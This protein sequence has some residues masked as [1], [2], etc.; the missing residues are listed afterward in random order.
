MANNELRIKPPFEEFPFTSNSLTVSCRDHKTEGSNSI[1]PCNW[2]LRLYLLKVQGSM[3]RYRRLATT[4]FSALFLIQKIQLSNPTAS[5]SQCYGIPPGLGSSRLISTLSLGLASLMRETLEGAGDAGSVEESW[6]SM[7]GHAVCS[8]TLL[9]RSFKAFRAICLQIWESVG[10]K[11]HEKH[12][13][14]NVYTC[15]CFLNNAA[16]TSHYR[17]LLMFSKHRLHLE[18]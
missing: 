16:C 10:R 4:I 8:S 3:L 14:K 2:P 12:R 7:L 13:N 5:R 1:C 6:S 17:N 11:F 15:K 9:S 18:N